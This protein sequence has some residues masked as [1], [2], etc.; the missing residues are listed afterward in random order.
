MTETQRNVL[1]V[2]VIGAAVS[3]GLIATQSIVNG[4]FGVISGVWAATW[5]S[6][7][8]TLVT[9]IL[10]LTLTGRIAR[11]RETLREYGSWWWFAIGLCGMPI[12]IGM[13]LGI[14]VI[15]VA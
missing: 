10:C 15:G 8:G 4:D 9:V 7:I 2:P 5:V 6:F 11:T 14:P 13:A 1:L 3:G 12:V